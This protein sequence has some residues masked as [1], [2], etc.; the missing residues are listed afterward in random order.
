M[1]N[2]HQSNKHCFK[3]FVGGLSHRTEDFHLRS[4]FK[5]LGVITEASV[6]KDKRT[7][8]SKGYGF[9]TFRHEQSYKAA[10]EAEIY[11][12][13]LKADIHPLKTKE[14]LQKQKK[15]DQKLK[16]FVGGINS[17]VKS[18]ELSSFFSRYG[19]VQ[20]ARVLYDGKTCV[21]RGFGFVLY[22]NEESVKRALAGRN[23]LKGRMMDCK[24][25]SDQDVRPH[26]KKNGR[27]QNMKTKTSLR[28][29]NGSSS[30]SKTKSKSSNQ[31]PHKSGKRVSP[32]DSEKVKFP[33]PQTQ[34]VPNQQKKFLLQSMN[35]PK[36]NQNWKRQEL[37]AKPRIPTTV[38][39][40]QGQH[41][42]YI[43]G[44]LEAKFNL[45]LDYPSLP[46]PNV[47]RFSQRQY[48][49]QRKWT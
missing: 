43:I 15:M 47:P 35:S 49:S 21:S 41:P 32:R 33:A 12:D 20:E 37:P 40:P 30:G 10:L 6:I 23:F 16:I 2:H 36:N 29:S 11:L 34:K 3:I 19:P 5:K 24:R 26:Q 42:F 8:Q 38:K 44:F 28:S 48:V 22:K 27:L 46:I 13:G 7:R 17:T 18:Q 31:N 4:A 9:L 39:I 1:H 25:F 14:K 45:N